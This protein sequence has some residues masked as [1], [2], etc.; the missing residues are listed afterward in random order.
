MKRPDVAARKREADGR[1]PAA[2]AARVGEYA[3]LR[4]QGA[5]PVDAAIAVGLDPYVN[6]RRYE[7]WYQ[8]AERGDRHATPQV[9]RSLA[10]TF[11]IPLAVFTIDG[12]EQ[13]RDTERVA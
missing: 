6:G 12:Y 3:D 2:F 8:A 7:R 9:L 11:K 5:R 10:S 13:I 1:W 4:R